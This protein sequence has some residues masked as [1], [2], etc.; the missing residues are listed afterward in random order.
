MAF[1]SIW[2]IL[3]LIAIL[4]LIIFFSNGKNAV[5][6]GLTIG[7]IIGVIIGLYYLFT[8]KG[9]DWII[10]KKCAIIGTLVGLIAEII[11]RISKRKTSA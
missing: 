5:W 9:F 8:S 2:N 11:G 3:G 7:T 1:L 4:A 10:L 6:G